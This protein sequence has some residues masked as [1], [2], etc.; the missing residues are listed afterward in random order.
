[1]GDTVKMI[2]EG[3]LCSCCGEYIG[4]PVGYSRECKSCRQAEEGIV[5]NDD[6]DDLLEDDNEPDE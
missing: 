1:M 3:I 4:K 2:L 6:D 5:S